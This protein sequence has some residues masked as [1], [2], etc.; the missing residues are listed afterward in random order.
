MIDYNATLQ[1]FFAEVVTYLEK[2]QR[3]VRDKKH[4]DK[5]KAGIDVIQRIAKNPKKYADY[6]ARIGED[7]EWLGQVLVPLGTLDERVYL[8]YSA[9]VNSMNDLNGGDYGY[10]KDA[11]KKLLTA[12]KTMKFINST[13]MLKNITFMFKSPRS[14]AV[15]SK[16]QYQI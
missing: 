6:N 5:I 15:Q 1:I 3:K 11:Q 8:T 7:M 14:F 2:L 4:R 13:N 16:K 9:V 10:R 12:L